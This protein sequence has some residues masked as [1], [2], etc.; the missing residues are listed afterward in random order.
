MGSIIIGVAGL[1]AM[2]ATLLAAGVVEA[3]ES[4]ASANVAP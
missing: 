3:A 1:A 2:A 4:V